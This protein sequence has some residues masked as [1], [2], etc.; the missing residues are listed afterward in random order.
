MNVE[1]VTWR[2]RK[3]AVV[4]NHE[5]F[6][7]GVCSLGCTDTAEPQLLDEAI[8][9][10]KVSPLNTTLGRT[11]IGTDT[12][13]VQLVHGTTKLSLAISADGLLVVD[14]EDT[15]LVAVEC[16]RLTVTLQGRLTSESGPCS[17]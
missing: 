1:I 13:D 14:P 6:G 11:G 9:Q 17:R 4:V 16:Q 5:L 3:S 15:G 10:R 12:G 7:K 2:L 8:L